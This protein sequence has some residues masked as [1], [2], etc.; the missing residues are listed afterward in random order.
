M[1]EALP[2]LRTA[3]KRS[4]GIEQRLEIEIG[5]DAAL[6]HEG[7]AL[8]EHGRFGG[9]TTNRRDQRELIERLVERDP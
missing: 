9:V 2:E 3:G 7:R 6:A 8:F 1:L 4:G 5:R